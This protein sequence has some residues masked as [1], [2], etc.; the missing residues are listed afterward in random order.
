M[1]LKSRTCPRFHARESQEQLLGKGPKCITLIH[2]KPKSQLKCSGEEGAWWR[3]RCLSAKCSELLGSTATTRMPGGI[4]L[5]I[6]AGKGGGPKGRFRSLE[7]WGLSCII[8]VPPQEDGAKG[9]VLQIPHKHLGEEADVWG[10]RVSL[11]NSAQ[12]LSC[13][14]GSG[15]RCPQPSP[16]P[17]AALQASRWQIGCGCEWLCLSFGFARTGFSKD[18]SRLQRSLP[19]LS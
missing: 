13:F 8:K 14:R 1:F 16:Q 4:I 9:P 18:L 7:L 17:V 2:F 5:S 11:F 10:L 15:S 19:P 12:R 3:W 6:F